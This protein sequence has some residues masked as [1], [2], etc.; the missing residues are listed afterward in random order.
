LKHNHPAKLTAIVSAL[1]AIMFLA[2]LFLAVFINTGTSSKALADD[3]SCQ[4][5][6]ETNHKVCGRFLQ[7]WQQNGSLTQQGFPTSDIFNEQNAPPPAGDGKIHL[8]QYFQRARFEQHSEN[9]APNDVLL[10]LL[11]REQY[12]TKYVPQAPPPPAPPDSTSCQ[13]FSQTGFTTCGKFLDY[14]ISHGGVAQQGYP[15]SLVFEEKNADPPAGDGKLHLVQYYERARFEE[16]LESSTNPVQLGLLG[17]EQYI[18]KYSRNPPPTVVDTSTPQPVITTPPIIYTTVA[19]PATTAPPPP[20]ATTT[21]APPP[22]TTT[23]PAPNGQVT[24]SASVSNSSPTQNST[25][26]VSGKF[27]VGG[28]PVAGVSMNATWNYKT[29]TSYCDGTTGSDGVASCSRDI[30]RAAKG[31]TVSVNLSFSYNGQ[32]YTASTSFTPQ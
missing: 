13:T 29:T 8:V 2:V 9:A 32:T 23:A 25:V 20:P 28:Q 6:S 12:G 11:G 10:G 22:A 24:V 26:T 16:H 31:Y 17:S 19:P 15:I 21:T 7:Y 1:A 5:F 3:G 18:A 14:W 4:F 30:G 27:L